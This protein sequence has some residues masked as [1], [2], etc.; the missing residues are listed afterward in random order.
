MLKRISELKGST[1]AACATI[2]THLKEG[3]PLKSDLKP[4]IVE[5]RLLAGA[6]FSLESLI[7]ELGENSENDMPVTE[8]TEWPLL[9]GCEM[10]VSALQSVHSI[11]TPDGLKAARSSLLDNRSKLGFVLGSSESL[12]DIMLQF[13]ILGSNSIPQLTMK[14]V[15]TEMVE[16]SPQTREETEPSAEEVSA[17]LTTLNSSDNDREPAEYNKEIALV[18]SRRITTNYRTAATRWPEYAERYWQKLRPQVCSLFRIQR[19]YSFVQ[20]VLEYARETFP[21]ALGPLALSPRLLLELTD[22][23]CDG[24]VSSLHI[25]AALGLPNLCRDLLS[26]GADINQASIL[27]TPLFCSLMGTK[28]LAT[29]AEPESWGS[30]LVGGYSDVERAA[31]ILLL[32]DEGADCTYKYHW[33]NADEVSLA[34]LA[35]WVAMNTKHEAIFTRIMKGGSK[36]DGAFLE[37]MQRETLVM[38][39]LFNKARFARL[40]TFVYDLTLTDIVSET[41]EYGDLQKTVSQLMKHANI[42]FS[43]SEESGKITTLNDDHI[44]EVTRNAVLDFDVTLIERLTSDPRFDPNLPFGKNGLSGTILH[45]A[46]EGSQLEIMDILIAAGADMGARDSNKR[47]PIMV[48]EDLSALSKLVLE[49]GASTTDTD[50]DGRT[51]WHLCAFT[52]DVH[53]LKWLWEHDPRKDE[54][55]RR[56]DRFGLTPLVASFAYIDALAQPPR[57]LRQPAPLAARFLLDACREHISLKGNEQLAE[58]AVK[59]GDANL[60]KKVFEIIPEAIK[61]NRFLLKYLNLSVSTEC[62]KVILDKCR[63]LPWQFSNGTTVA[64][65]IITNTRLS[66]GRYGAFAVPTG[67]PSCFPKIKREDYERLLTP[68]VLKSRDIRNRGLWVRF[69]DDILPLLSGIGTAHPSS[70]YFLSG[71]IGLAVR[72]LVQRGVLADYE[73]ETGKCAIN[74]IAEARG[75]DEQLYWQGWHYPFITAILETSESSLSYL[76]SLSPDGPNPFASSFEAVML[77]QQ[78][79]H[80]RLSR[81]VGLLVNTGINVHAPWDQLLGVSLFEAVLLDDMDLAMVRT[82]L[83]RSRPGDI[84]TRQFE[85]FEKLHVLLENQFAVQVIFKLVECGMDPN[86][87]P[88]NVPGKDGSRGVSF[89][90]SMLTEATSQHK[91]GIACALLQTGADPGLAAS[92]GYNAMIA[93]CQNGQTVVL[94]EI[95]EHQPDGFDW[96]CVYQG[97]DGVTYNALQIA[98]A[99]SHRDILEVLILATPLIDEIDATTPKNGL[100]PAHLAAKAGSLECIKIL[101]KFGADLTA[102]DSSGR[103]P[104]FWAILRSNTEVA[105]YLKDTL[106]EPEE[107]R[108]QDYGIS[109]LDPLNSTG[110]DVQELVSRPF[111]GRTPESTRL[112]EQ[113]KLGKMIADTISRHR[114][115]SGGLFSSLLNHISKE[116]LESAILPCDGCTLLSYTASQALISPMVELLE[117][118]FTGFVTSCKEH[119]PEGYN[120]LLQGCLHF[121]RLLQVNI[122]T[123]AKKVYSFIEKCLDAYLAEG[124]PWFHLSQPPIHAICQYQQTI[125]GPDLEHQEKLLKIFIDHLGVGAEIRA[126][127]PVRVDG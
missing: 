122:F 63:E 30:L 11:A 110:L 3:S 96:K 80:H 70:L 87:L 83:S 79:V 17:W 43:F 55:L 5:L 121:Q 9:D 24:S 103:S 47:T 89:H 77:L 113:R 93:A 119:W 115:N 86:L 120:A 2:R 127:G 90:W 85:T 74:Y 62:L 124:R 15:D 65:T 54:N 38:R 73:R 84:I 81:L 8:T 28:V 7:V 13:S 82:L 105:E 123:V 114:P 97:E 45:T 12:Q 59:W 100:S 106:L 72:C 126:L 57:G 111:H 41:L 29:R 60:V 52:N 34:G 61:I 88:K 109:M 98:A 10:L 44:A 4:L 92:D 99:N 18:Q 39:G 36:L 117:L 31:T 27:G 91:S 51:I 32:L 104:L 33:K 49:H 42:K 56:K 125:G 40:L 35:F 71:F 67:H 112:E 23:L 101:A 108:E 102:T 20:W 116:E 26:M 21:R 19:S 14:N 53:L 37:L 46:T 1:L 25:A 76:P 78:A 94:E 64:E 58:Y 107:E 16:S 95:I 69:C 6:L 118:G 68:A 75:T 66:A 50:E 22:A 48:V